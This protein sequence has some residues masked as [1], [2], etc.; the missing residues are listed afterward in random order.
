MKFLI[1]SD[2]F[3]RAV[4]WTART[5]PNHPAVPVLGGLRLSA[6]DG[7]LEVGAFDYE[8]AA[9]TSLDA[10]VQQDGAVLVSGRMLADIAARLP[11]GDLQVTLDGSQVELVCG[12]A[13]FTQ[14]SM[15]LADYP[16]LPAMPEAAGTVNARDF[17][18]AAAQTIIA[19]GTDGTIPMLTAL[20]IDFD[21]PALTLAATDRYRLA[22]RELSWEPA[23]TPPTGRILV[24][25]RTIGDIVKTMAEDATL[26]LA[27]AYTDKGDSHSLGVQ[28]G[29]RQLI[30]RLYDPEYVNYPAL[31]PEEFTAHARLDT[32]QFTEAVKR[33]GV[34]AERSTPVRLTF[35]P[36]Q[37]GELSLAAGS[38]DSV[39]GA[40]V[41]PARF[42]GRKP[43]TICLHPKYLVDGLNALGSETAHLAITTAAKPAVLTA[44]P[45]DETTA[46]YRHLIMPIR[47]AG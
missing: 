3:A 16:A 23:L 13:R 42:D 11:K 2:V 9:R 25:H 7:A 37:D 15:P 47:L 46:P 17:A 22:V 35:T 1:P 21:G 19:A 33:V 5:L 18:H 24:D 36:G 27:L 31:L 38:G 6:Q 8:V 34:T 4:T 10:D 41:I 26:T 39:T 29:G 28:V 30:T 20:C 12:R 40:D 44:V 43:L 32:A 45:M 14:L